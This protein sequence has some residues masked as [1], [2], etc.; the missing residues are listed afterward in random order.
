M[1]VDLT[2]SS[3]APATGQKTVTAKASGKIV[4]YNNYSDKTQRLI[5]NTRFQSPTGKIYRINESITV[6]GTHKEG[7]KIVPGSIETT[8][9]ADEPGPDYNSDVID[10]TIPGLKGDARFDKI[11]ARAKG[12]ITG[13]TSGITKSVSDEDLSR[14]NDD[15]AVTL[16]TKLRSKIRAN[17]T[18]AQ[19]VFPQAITIEFSKSTLAQDPQDTP[20][21]AKVERKGS[22]AAIVFDRK[23]LAQAIAKQTIPQYQNDDVTIPEL[24]KLAYESQKVSIKELIDNE[25]INFTLNGSTEIRYSIDTRDIQKSL[26]GIEKRAFQGVM[27]GMQM[28]DKAQASIKP[29]WQSTFPKNPDDIKI[30]IKESSE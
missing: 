24:E 27:A 18:D 16:E 29:F 9:F 25:K 14:V 10:F 15:L 30:V 20:N 6:P 4:V 5:K 12:A 26:A 1:Q 13:G 3:T 8:V 22:I 11:Y 23:S 2:E 19:I 21:T 7:A 17:T 28:I